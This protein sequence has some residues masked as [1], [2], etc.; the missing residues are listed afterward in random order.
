MR[1]AVVHA[2]DQPLRV[3]DVAKP[4]PG[5]GQV[6]VKIET[7]GLC[8]TDIHAAHGDWPV[9][10]HPP[11]IPGHEGV[12]I[13]ESVGTGVQHCRRGRPRGHPVARLRLRSL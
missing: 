11:F 5:P 4:E 7:C 13:V 12:G 2:F 1:A 3:E 9:K 6:V 10:P 8:H